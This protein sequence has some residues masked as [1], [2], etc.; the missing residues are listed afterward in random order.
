M[1]DLSKGWRAGASYLYV[2][3]LEGPSVAWEYLRRS[4]PYQ[5]FWGRARE[6][7]TLDEALPWGL[8][9]R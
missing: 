9:F 1:T 7:R 2:L 6:G 4:V 5:E 8:R 3:G